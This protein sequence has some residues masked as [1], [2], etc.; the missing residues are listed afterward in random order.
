MKIFRR[1]NLGI[2]FFAGYLGGFLYI[3]FVLF[4]IIALL[5]KA[6]GVDD[7]LPTLSSKIALDALRLSLF[8]SAISMI[9]VIVVGTPF[10]YFLARSRLPA[11]RIVDIFVELPLVLPPVVAGL[12]MLMVFGR[13]GLLGRWLEPFGIVIPFT[14]VSVIFAQI[15]V[16]APFYIRAAR[17]GFQMVKVEYEEL[18]QTLGVGPLQTFWK[19]TIP[20]AWPSLLGGIA[21]AWARAIS[22]FGATIMFAGNFPGKTQTMPLAILS[23]LESDLSIAIIMAVMLIFVSFLLLTILGFLR[24]KSGD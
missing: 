11:I 18:S 17:L 12:A 2:P 19:I 22:E 13:Y 23:A 10:S 16:A 24:I 20:L 5:V 4:P 7:F 21:L 8:S 1:S 15:F 14:L 6:V 9:I 3:T